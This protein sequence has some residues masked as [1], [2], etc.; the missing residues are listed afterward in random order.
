MRKVLSV[1][2]VLVLS[3]SMLFSFGCGK[4][5]A[6][7]FKYSDKA[8]VKEIGGTSDTY[9]AGVAED[10]YPSAEECAERYVLVE[11]VGKNGAADIKAG[12]PVDATEAEIQKLG[13]P[14]NDLGEYESI[15]KVTVTYVDGRDMEKQYA[16]A[17]AVAKNKES[18]QT[19]Y[20]IKYADGFRYITPKIEK[21][22]AVTKSYFE[23][24]FDE[25]KYSNCT[26]E[27]MMAMNIKTNI[28]GQGV[29]AEGSM[30]IVSDMKVKIAE[31][32]MYLELSASTAASGA[33]K[34]ML[35][36]D[37][38]LGMSC[39]AYI[40][41]NGDVYVYDDEA[42]VWAQS[43]L[44]AIN[45]TPDQLVP[46]GSQE[47]T[48][49]T[50]YKKT[51]Y[52]FELNMEEILNFVVET[53]GKAIGDMASFLD[54]IKIDGYCRFYVSDGVL[55]GVREKLDLSVDVSEKGESCKLNETVILELVCKDYGKT[56]VVLPEEIA[57]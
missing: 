46:F 50:Y 14:A 29:K 32:G 40:M 30:K 10:V 47:E 38:S 22:E 26:Y 16:T 12:A 11:I 9:R 20:V 51:D 42:K 45:V 53:L 24:V 57:G 56:V 6:V 43:S 21:G 55:S 17:V 27:M 13:I 15:K 37:S 28:V 44:A 39:K 34:D 48:T 5:S 52:G 18:A 31:N 3:L 23:S 33:Y 7:N 2:I 35:D 19:V 1:C 4:K 36:D 54:V 25:S 8:F 41:K 49:F